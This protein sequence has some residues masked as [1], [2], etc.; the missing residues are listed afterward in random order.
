MKKVF[1]MALLAFSSLT[2]NAQVETPQASPSSK[3]EQTVGLTNV[4]IDYSRPGAKGR[5][6]YGDLVPYGKNWRTGAN[7]NTVITFDEDI[8]VNGQEL[9]RGKYALYTT[10]KADSW[11]V[12]FYSATDNWGLPKTWDESKVALRTT[13]KPETLNKPVESF[14]ISLNNLSN[15][16]ATLDLAWERTMVSV[17]FTVPTNKVAMNSIEKALAGPS[18]GDYFSAAQYFYQTENDLNKAL[19]WINNAVSLT[20]E[21]KDTPFWYLRLKSLI[22]AK[23]G[24]KKGAIATAKSSLDGAKKAGNG[25]YEKMNKDSIAEWS[26]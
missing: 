3:V 2:I 15:D 20:P 8:K 6:V 26:K 16:S 4:S 24:D 17:P 25:D 19:T 5:T 9:K 22:Q 10:P 18:A 7:A 21:G 11:D 12:I 13:V 1:I 14:T 23:L